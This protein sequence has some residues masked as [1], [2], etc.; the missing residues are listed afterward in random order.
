MHLVNK[1]EGTRLVR[2]PI[3]QDGIE[4]GVSWSTQ[5]PVTGLTEVGP[6]SSRDER[7]PERLTV[8]GGGC[9][10]TSDGHGNGS[11]VYRDSHSPGPRA[12]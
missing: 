9:D 5:I 12:S 10:P 7:S 11:S 1:S 4:S 3:G 2:M 8:S 6:Q